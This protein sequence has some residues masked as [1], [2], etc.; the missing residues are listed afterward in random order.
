MRR[1]REEDCVLLF[2][3]PAP[4]KYKLSVRFTR[5]YFLPERLAIDVLVNIFPR[6]AS[7]DFLP[8]FRFYADIFV[9]TLSSKAHLFDWRQ[10]K[11]ATCSVSEISPRPDLNIVSLVVWS[12]PL[13]STRS[14]SYDVL[15]N[16][17][18]LYQFCH[19]FP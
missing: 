9:T 17:A 19:L 15:G 8:L 6:M 7:I 10:K 11:C 5:R 1:R 2:L 16:S 13:W 3:N 18:Q 14:G 4:H 12:Q